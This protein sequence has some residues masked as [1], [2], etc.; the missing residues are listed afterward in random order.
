MRRAIAYGLVVAIALSAPAGAFAAVSPAA[1]AKQDQANGTVKGEAKN[2]NG[3][4]LAQNKVRIRNSS[5]GNIA[6]ELT[7]DAAGT[8]T[9]T[10]PAGSYVIEVLGPNG[11][12]I[13]LSPVITVAAGATA[14]ISVTASSVAAVGAG[15]AAGGVGLFGLGATAT[16]AVLG[17]AAT[18]AIVGVKAANKDASPSK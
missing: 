8:F 2:G 17:A 5:T 10:V 7:T 9:G 3:E 16:V 6:S 14:T 4:K 13:G 12:V 15:A 18:V 1:K 11:A